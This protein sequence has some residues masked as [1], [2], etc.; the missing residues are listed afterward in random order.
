MTKIDKAVVLAAGR[1]TRMRE[2][3]SDLPKPML[4]VREKPILQHIIEGMKSAGIREFL[5]I[6]G[7]RAD[8]VRVWYSEGVGR[9]GLY[10]TTGQE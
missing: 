6:V 9:A 8:V 2:L 5:I 4:R 7:W 3:T 1:G 10:G